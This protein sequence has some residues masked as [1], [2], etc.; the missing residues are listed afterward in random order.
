M[1]ET[2][3]NA[4]LSVSDKVYL[5]TAGSNP[6]APF[7]VYGVDGENSVHANNGTSTGIAMGYVALYTKNGTDPLFNAIPEALEA[8]GAAVYLNSVQYE[9][10]TSYLHYEW[11]WEIA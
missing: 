1:N 2:I 4:L 6:K 7:I 3:K 11:L 5:Y 8:A 10:E 9:D